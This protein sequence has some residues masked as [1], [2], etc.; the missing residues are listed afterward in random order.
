LAIDYSTGKKHHDKIDHHAVA[1][2]LG[3]IEQPEDPDLHVRKDHRAIAAALNKKEEIDD[4]SHCAEH[5]TIHVT[6]MIEMQS[7]NRGSIDPATSTMSATMKMR[8]SKW[9][10]TSLPIGFTECK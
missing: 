7:R 9:V 1:T 3:V 10:L 6:T 8:K 2:A 5:L 4:S